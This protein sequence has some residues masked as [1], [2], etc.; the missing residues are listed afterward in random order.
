[1][2]EVKRDRDGERD[3]Q[4]DIQRQRADRE[5]ERETGERKSVGTLKAVS[6]T[7]KM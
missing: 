4:R 7:L 5:S 1:V 2:R 6:A 3:T